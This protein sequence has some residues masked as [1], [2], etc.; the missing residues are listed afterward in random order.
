MRKDGRK[1]R[2]KKK[3]NGTGPPPLV[4]TRRDLMRV[5][6]CSMP[7]IDGLLAKRILPSFRLGGR[8]VVR[9][10]SIVRLLE[11][12]EKAEPVTWPGR[13]RTRTAGQSL[14]SNLSTK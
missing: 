4:W 3:T 13:P 14:D 12:L 8:R 2:P 7:A 6:N 5:L 11:E 1:V 10:D 9:A